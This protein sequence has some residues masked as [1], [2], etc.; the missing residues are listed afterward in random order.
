MAPS[1][2]P[3]SLE[4]MVRAVEK[5]RERLLRATAA[6]EN[7]SIP[8][9]VCGGNAVAVWVTRVD[10][11][12]VRNT[13]DVDILIRRSDLD[14]VKTALMVAGFD[15]K[16]TAGLDLFLDGPS[17]RARDA[18]HIVFAGEKVRPEELLP[19]PDVTESVPSDQFRVLDLEALV[20]IKLTSFRDKDRTHLRDLLDVG[21]IDGNWCWRYPDELAARLQVLID[22]PDG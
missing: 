6:L 11:S 19:N 3:F 2:G 10:E 16:H 12:A 15:Y 21:L 5:V 22:T 1:L 4:R 7:A 13:R 17:A 20:R 18:V 14:A 8:Y 9:A